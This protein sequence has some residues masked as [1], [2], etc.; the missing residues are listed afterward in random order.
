MVA[1]DFACC[2]KACI[3]YSLLATARI[4]E[5]PVANTK[6]YRL[7]RFEAQGLELSPGVGGGGGS[8]GHANVKHC[9]SF[10]QEDLSVGCTALAREP[11]CL[12]SN[13]SAVR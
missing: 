9:Q 6:Q 4:A 12:L 2:R 8:A 10:C 11:C 1:H 3:R 5:G 7:K 13:L